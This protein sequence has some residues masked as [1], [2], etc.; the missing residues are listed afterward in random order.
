MLAQGAAFISWHR[1]EGHTLPTDFMSSCITEVATSASG[2]GEVGAPNNFSPQV[3]ATR[4]FLCL[5]ILNMLTKQPPH[6]HQ[7]PQ[8]CPRQHHGF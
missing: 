8:G 6:N 5:N 7:T 4:L 1:K 3:L 2:K